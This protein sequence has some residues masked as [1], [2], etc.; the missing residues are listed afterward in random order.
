MSL[1]SWSLLSWTNV[2]WR[3]KKTRRCVFIFIVILKK[4][5]KQTEQIG[6]AERPSAPVLR[7]A[8]IDARKSAESFTRRRFLS[9]Q[10]IK[11]KKVKLREPEMI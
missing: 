4:D 6:G 10:E 7:T 3:Q 11:E 2:P 5:S 9:A 1:V 8:T